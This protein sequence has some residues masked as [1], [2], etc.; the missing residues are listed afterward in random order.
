MLLFVT[1]LSFT[2]HPS[3]GCPREASDF[4]KW[5]ELNFRLT[6]LKQDSIAWIVEFAR[7]IHK[8]GFILYIWS[9]NKKWLQHRDFLVQV[10]GTHNI[11]Q[12]FSFFFLIFKEVCMSEAGISWILKTHFVHFNTLNITSTLSN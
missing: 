5:A 4:S 3:E 7:L 8:N 1:L 6:L 9:K 2:E 10:C 11:F 12:Q